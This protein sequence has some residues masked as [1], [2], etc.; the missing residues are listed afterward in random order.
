MKTKNRLLITPILFLMSILMV[1]FVVEP[2]QAAV[3]ESYRGEPLCLPGIYP[4]QQNDCL[5]MG[6]SEFL[7]T[8][9]QK[10]IPVPF[11]PLPIFKPDI[12]YT[13]APVPYLTVGENAFPL[14]ASLDDAIAR[15]PTRYLEAG[16][17]FLAMAERV[18]RDDG[19]YY[20]LAN[21]LWVEAGEA[22]T[23]CCIYS[24]R[25]QGLLFYQNPANS[26]GW[27]LDQTDVMET[28]GYSSQNTGKVHYRED[29]VQIYDVVEADGTQWYMIG[30]N[31]WVERRRI[32]QFVINPIPPEGV[33]NNRWIEIN[34]Y[35]QTLG[36]YEDGKLVFAA[37]IASGI[38]PFFTQPGLFQIY[39]KLD[40]TNMSGSFEVDRSDYYYLEDVPWTLYYDE[41]R[42]IH[43][44]YWR[45][46]FGYPQSHGCVNLSLTDSR[47][48]FEW[49]EVGDWVYVW[50]PSG[51]TPTDPSLYSAGGA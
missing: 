49:A 8:M 9:D 19:V 16:F 46:Y 17:K 7:T 48:V 6:P 42:A 47:V 15:N 21:G 39:E 45:T 32:R 44:A 29:V 11:Q 10:G 36:I 31:E 14:Y 3:Q 38:D 24:G 28:P 2:V 33:D 25:F 26:F 5:A 51:E 40:R 4:I 12:S 37:L 20:R 23:S 34:L 30:L 1:G 41:A 43:G 18:N 13:Y 50:D 35:E 22:D 27:I